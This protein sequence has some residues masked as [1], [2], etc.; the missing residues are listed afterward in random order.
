MEHKV[1]N[2]KKRESQRNAFIS[3]NTSQVNKILTVILWVMLASVCVMYLNGWVTGAVTG[4]LL[5]EVLLATLLIFKT[6]RHTLT[7]AILFMAILTCTV[8]SVGGAYTG[9]IISVVLAIVSLYMDRRILFAFGGLYAVTYT[10]MHSAF[11]I[12]Y[13]TTMSFLGLLVVILYFVC[14]RGAHLIQLSNKN[15]EEANN[16][17]GVVR[18]NTTQLHNNIGH[19]NEDIS[20]LRE[21]SNTM[22]LKI[23]EV[24]SDAAD[25]SSSIICIHEMMNVADMEMSEISRMSHDLAE[26]AQ[27]ANQSLE[28]GAEQFRQMDQQTEIINLAVSESLSTIQALHVSMEQVNDFL[29]AINKIASETNLLALNASIEAARAGAAGAGF[30]VVAGQIKNLAQQS[31]QLVQD[32]DLI[33]RDINTK[34]REV[35][36]KATAGDAAAKEGEQ[37]TRQVLSSFTHIRQAFETIDHYIENEMSKITQVS[38]VFSQIR[39]QSEHISE[40]SQKHLTATNEMLSAT[41]DQYES[42]DVI[43]HSIGSINASSVS[44]QALIDQRQNSFIAP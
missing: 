27:N 35:L 32:I 15:E 2:K 16:M 44:L 6:K 19:C 34:T 28:L 31:S 7:M 25:Q 43:Y 38:G 8:D 36:Q 33:V 11:D 14:K 21:I 3:E 9:M 20:L 42:M 39:E 30:S 24:A 13:F 12:E 26:T 1:I 17:V 23:N 41:R 10:V 37:V 5:F 29:A 18:E 4:S 40:I 22:S